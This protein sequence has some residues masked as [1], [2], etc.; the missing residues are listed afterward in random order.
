M[1]VD[2]GSAF[3]SVRWT[4]R[5][6]A[7]G[8]IAQTSVVESHNSIGFSERYYAPLCRVFNKIKHENPKMDRRIA[9]RIFVKAMNDTLGPNGYV[10][11]FLVF[12]CVPRF[13]AVDSKPPE[14]QSHMDALSRARQE[15]MRI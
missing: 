10:P 11:S 9:F 2:Q 8:T 7:V 4:R 1:R 14:Q 5:A 13:P 3:T 12:G 6:D 15:M